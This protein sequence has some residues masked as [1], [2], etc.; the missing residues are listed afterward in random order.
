[1]GVNNLVAPPKPQIE[2]A[3]SERNSARADVSPLAGLYGAGDPDVARFGRHA[4][5]AKIRSDL[6]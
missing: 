2:E 4:G 6:A 3:W 1:M 5:G